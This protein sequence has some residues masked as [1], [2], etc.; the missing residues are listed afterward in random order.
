MANQ[1]DM[2]H[3]FWFSKFRISGCIKWAKI[4]KYSTVWVFKNLAVNRINR[5]F[6]FFFPIRKSLFSSRAA[7]PVSRVSRLRRS[8]A[9]ALLSLNLKKKRDYSQSRK[10]MA[11]SPGRKKVAVRWDTTVVCY[12]QRSWNQ[13]CSR[14]ALQWYILSMEEGFQYLFPCVHCPGSWSHHTM[15]TCHSRVL[16][17]DKDPWS[18]HLLRS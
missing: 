8:R 5:G 18:P 17:P 3:A 11:F 16:V 2:S 14:D 13:L 6:F 1:N 10:C 12:L 7:A 4:I 9:R 15:Q